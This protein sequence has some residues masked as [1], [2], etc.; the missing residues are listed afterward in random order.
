MDT[1]TFRADEYI[2]KVSGVTREVIASATFTVTER[3]AMTSTT[4]IPATRTLTRN[5]TD[6]DNADPADGNTIPSQL[7][8]IIAGLSIL[9]F[10]R[11][12]GKNLISHRFLVEHIEKQITLNIFKI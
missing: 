1:S 8:G 9:G 12:V 7:A 4:S 5:N 6:N 11:L 10:A 2:V 3:P